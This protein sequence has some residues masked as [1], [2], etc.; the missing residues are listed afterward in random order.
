MPGESA[1]GRRRFLSKAAMTMAAAQLGLLGRAEANQR[2]QREL[3]AI[4][5]ATEWLNS[6]RLTASSLLGKVVLVD[7]CTYT[8]INW[9]R[10]LPYVRAWAQT[11]RPGLVVI[12]VHTPEFEFEK[13]IDNVRRA[14]GQMKTEYPMV[15]DNDYSIWNA[16]R[17]QYWPALYFLDTGGRIRH[18]HFGEGEYESSERAI[19]KRLLEAG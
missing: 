14:V 10:T 4:G 6:P 9:L 11:Y 5:R 1:Y 2:G 13:N 18:R 15:V 3:T 12:G 17:N 8:C 19:Q 7:F 16:F